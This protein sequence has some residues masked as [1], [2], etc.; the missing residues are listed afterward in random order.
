MKVTRDQRDHKVW[1]DRQIE[2]VALVNQLSWPTVQTAI[3]HTSDEQ[4]ISSRNWTVRQAA[5]CLHLVKYWTSR[6]SASEGKSSLCYWRVLPA[7]EMYSS[8]TAVLPVS[9]DILR[10]LSRD[11]ADIIHFLCAIRSTAI[12]YT[13]RLF[14]GI[15]WQQAPCV[16]S[17][18]LFIYLFI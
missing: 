1:T 15:W 5:C 17:I 2:S 13:C 12:Q 4:R 14:C 10:A 9:N 8:E 16:R 11:C 18:Y 7:T 3:T 6:I